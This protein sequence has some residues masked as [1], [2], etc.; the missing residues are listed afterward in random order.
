MNE[1][2]KIHIA[3]LEEDL[4]HIETLKEGIEIWQR[5]LKSRVFDGS[6]P[7]DIQA[8]VSSL[9]YEVVK[10]IEGCHCHIERIR[11]ESNAEL[12]QK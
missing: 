11:K 4:E 9:K 3:W 5:I 2:Q 8:V 7:R 1:N 12:S 10:N 6:W